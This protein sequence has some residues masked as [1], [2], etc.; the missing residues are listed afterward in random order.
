MV[1]HLASTIHCVDQEIIGWLRRREAAQHPAIWCL[2]VDCRSHR[3][4]S[5]QILGDI[6]AGTASALKS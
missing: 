5:H 2:P 3:R 1:A 6:E 4:R